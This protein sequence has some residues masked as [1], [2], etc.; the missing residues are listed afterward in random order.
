MPH[1]FL[2]ATGLVAAGLFLLRGNL[3]SIQF[4]ASPFLMALAIPILVFACIGA[5][6]MKKE[7]GWEGVD[8][9]S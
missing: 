8:R 7:T 6:Q 1:S 5:L 3:L 4:G 9:A 2:T